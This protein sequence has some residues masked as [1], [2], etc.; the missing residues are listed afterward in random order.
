MM[1]KALLTAAIAAAAMNVSAV[2]L[3]LDEKYVIGNVHYTSY[4]VNDLDSTI[5]FGVGVGAPLDDVELI[6]D[7]ELFVEAGYIYFG[8]SSKEISNGF[9]KIDTSLTASSIYGAAKLRFEVQ[10]D[11]YVYGKLGLGY[12]MTE[13]DASGGG[14]SS[15]ASDSEMKLLYGAGAQYQYSDEISVGAEYVFHASDVTTLTGVVTYNF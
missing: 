12:I 10:D 3:D 2:E 8:E 11:I 15:S 5:G 6:G 13:A 7:T 14:F 4:D 1:K 9:V